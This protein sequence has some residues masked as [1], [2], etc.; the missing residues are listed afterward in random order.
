MTLLEDTALLGLVIA[1]LTL[2]VFASAAGWV[3]SRRVTSAPGRRW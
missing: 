2:L 1:V 3:L